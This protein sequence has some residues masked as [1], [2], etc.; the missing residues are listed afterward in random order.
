MSKITLEQCIDLLDR[1]A[2][3]ERY[4][5]ESYSQGWHSGDGPFEDWAN[6]IAEKYKRIV[7]AGSET[8]G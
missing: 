4:E 1:L 6:E 5:G 8:R 7:E 2:Y 3:P